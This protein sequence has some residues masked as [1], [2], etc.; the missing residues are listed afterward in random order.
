M[1]PVGLGVI[2]CGVIGKVHARDAAKREHISLVA[3]A[4]LREGAA[5]AVADELGV[6]KT[7]ASAEALLDDDDVEAVVLAL[8]TAAR[9]GLACK[10]F[11]RGKHVLVEKPIAKRAAEVEE[12]IAARGDLIAG[13]CSARFRMPESA[14]AASDFIA[15]GALGR[16]RLVRARGVS[17]AKERP[18]TLPPPWR[19]CRSMNG[20][21]ILVNWGCYDLDY[22][23]GITGWALKPRTVL[24]QTWPIPGRYAANVVPE[25]DAETYGTALVRCEDDAVILL[26]RGEYM[27]TKP[28]TIYEVIG[29]DGALHLDVYGEEKRIVHIAADTERGVIERTIWQSGL[30]APPARQAGEPVKVH[31]SVTSD[32]ALAIREGRQPGTPLEQAL[33][34]Q[35]ITDAI[36]ASAATGTAVE[37]N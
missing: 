9:E 24:A 22:V 14:R 8:P 16:L 7:Y 25:S 30:P 31:P 19:L 37:I 20:G 29:E 26:E 10:A 32:F 17:Q 21:G 1:D 15:T 5:R 27:P 4:D 35:K 33:I 28:E 11:A 18:E 13:C 23:L 34:V 3:V 36:Y 2:G 6:K 12:M